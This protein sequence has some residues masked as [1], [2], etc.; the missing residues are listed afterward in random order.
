MFLSSTRSVWATRRN[1]LLR[2]LKAHPPPP[3]DIEAAA[4][5]STTTHT[6][7][8]AYPDTEENHDR[9]HDHTQE[10]PATSRP[11]S[12]NTNTPRLPYSRLF[13]QFSALLLLFGIAW[14][15][16]AQVFL[17][18]GSSCRQ[19]SPHLWWTLFALVCV[20]Y[21][22]VAEL[23]LFAILVF[24]IIPICLVSL[25]HAYEASGLCTAQLLIN[26]I[27][28][29]LGRP[30]VVAPTR[31]HPEIGKLPKE[32]VAR[33]PLVMYIPHPS[34]SWQ[35]AAHDPPS[36]SYPPKEAQRPISSN[37]RPKWIPFG[38]NSKR[39]QADEWESQWE[40]GISLTAPSFLI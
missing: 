20:Q 25:P 26:S 23:F 19:S 27:L 32:T 39:R 36:H 12:R 28:L 13:S 34:T 22:A 3:N 37:Q 30:P 24:I 21:F 33:I 29:C 17:Y 8:G 38:S 1:K 31:I 14:W 2:Y 10:A 6:V 7:P 35:P 9:D 16:V 11:P 5:D 18:S 15:F 4:A 40:Q